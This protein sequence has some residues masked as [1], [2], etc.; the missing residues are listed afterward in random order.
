[1]RLGED[2]KSKTHETKQYKNLP[3]QEGDNC[4]ATCGSSTGWKD[5]GFTNMIC[6]KHVDHCAAIAFCQ[7]CRL[8][9]R[10]ETVR[11]EQHNLRIS[12]RLVEV[13]GDTKSVA[14]T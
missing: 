11:I 3:D 6:F 9:S 4:H 8:K 1:M 13:C 10:R 2:L 5:D 7:M 12:P 14:A